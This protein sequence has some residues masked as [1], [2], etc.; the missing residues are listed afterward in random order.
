M[1]DTSMLPGSMYKFAPLNE[2]NWIGWKQRVWALIE[3]RELDGYVD[4]SIPRPT[5]VDEQ[6]AWDKKDKAA[7]R[8]IK[9]SIGDANMAHILGAKTSKAMW[10]NL[11]LVRERRG[12]QGIISARR[13]LYRTEAEEGV[14]I[15]DDIAKYRTVQEELLMMGSEVT[16]L[17]F[18]VVLIASLPVSWDTFTSSLLGSQRIQAIPGNNNDVL[19]KPMY[20]SYEVCGILLEEYERR[21]SRGD[22]ETVMYSQGRNRSG[23]RPMMNANKPDSSQGRVICHNCGKAGHYARDCWSKGGGKE[24]QG[25]SDE[26]SIILTEELGYIEWRSN[27]L[28]AVQSVIEGNDVFVISPTGSGKST[29]YQVS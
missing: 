7:M 11:T 24:G 20:S 23:K 3:E 16:D 15:K 10:D 1:S 6:P 26:L 17:E 8:C 28:E 29:I 21:L 4:G 22:P 2:S 9:M 19:E 5:E 14:D 13:R 25:P 18:T 12:N 27:Q